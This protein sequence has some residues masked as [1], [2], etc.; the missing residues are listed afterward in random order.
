MAYGLLSTEILTV[1]AGLLI[2][3]LGLISKSAQKVSHLIAAAGL[4]VILIV[5]L[6]Y[7]RI[8]D[9]IFSGLY[10]IDSF[11]VFCKLIFIVAALLVVLMSDQYNKKQYPSRRSEFNAFL[12]FALVGMM[13]LA[14]AGEMIT[15]YVGLELMTITFYILTAYLNEEPASAEAGMKYLILG[16]VSSGILLF[17][18]SLVF[19]VTGHTSLAGIAAL[20]EPS[21]AMTA[22]IIM[23]TAG[24]GFK[25]A[26]MP[27]HMWSPDIYQ[28]A[29]T[30]V[31]AFLAVG[32]KAAAFAVIARVF[33]LAFPS[34]EFNWPVL[35]AVLA[36]VTMI[37]GNLIAIVQKNVKRLLA[38]SSIAQAGYLLSGLLSANELGLQ[39]LLFYALLYVFS[40]SGAFAVVVA[41]ENLKGD[42]DFASFANLAKRAPF[43]SMVMTVCLLSLAGIPPLAGF[44]GKFFIFSGVVSSGYLWLTFVALVMSMIS[45]YYYLL[46]VKIMFIGGV[47][48]NGGQNEGENQHELSTPLVI[49][50]PARLVMWVCF[51]GT[52]LM[53][54]YPEPVANFAK[55][56]ASSL[57][58]ALL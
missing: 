5:N 22:G 11:S 36:A 44:V 29:P 33:L 46:V 2:L 26:V 27:F 47:N 35:L 15:I 12:L 14:S 40:N 52:I 43:I 34:S 50:I 20:F 32:S 19:A 41:V 13:M 55:I 23:M 7:F 30:P 17:G 31:T 6:N 39:G 58:A 56:A 53:G 25:I 45:V 37:A 1:L 18:I 48:D 24:F 8:Q 16:A 9:H 42:S 51:L 4:L 3:I 54:V 57:L 38:Y 28:G 49:G 10:L 21:P